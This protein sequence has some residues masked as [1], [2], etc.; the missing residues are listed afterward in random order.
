[1][2]LEIVFTHPFVSHLLVK[3]KPCCVFSDLY[4]GTL[5]HQ[6]ALN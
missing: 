2:V 4:S 6:M 1:M 5:H 3:M